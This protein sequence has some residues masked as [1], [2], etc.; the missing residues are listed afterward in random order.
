MPRGWF[1]A[2]GVRPGA[3]IDKAAASEAVKARGF[4]P[5]KF[6]FGPGGGP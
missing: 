2:N 4:D 3:R 1:E 5:S 6:G